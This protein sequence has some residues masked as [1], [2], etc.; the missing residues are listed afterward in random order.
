MIKRV[1]ETETHTLT[2]A[3][4]E[5]DPMPDKAEL[6]QLKEALA[7]EGL[8]ITGR[9]EHLAGQG[10]VVEAKDADGKIVMVTV[11]RK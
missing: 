10:C 7:K 11:E 2:A 3:H 5:S 8:S 4:V 1:I 9:V 6:D